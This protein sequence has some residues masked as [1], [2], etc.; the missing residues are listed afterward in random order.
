MRGLM[1]DVPLRISG[2]IQSCIRYVGLVKASGQVL[3]TS[4][5][6]NMRRWAMIVA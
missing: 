4:I 5:A 3:L 1:M 6:F 2:L